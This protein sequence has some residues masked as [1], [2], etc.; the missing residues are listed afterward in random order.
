M[1]GRGYGHL[2]RLTSPYRY[3]MSPVMW[4]LVAPNLSA[5]RVQSVGLAMVVER[6]RARLAFKSAEYW[7][8]VA[9]VKAEARPGEILL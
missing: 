5:G 1:V 7:D 8:V 9:S 4:E 6:E 2:S 3:T